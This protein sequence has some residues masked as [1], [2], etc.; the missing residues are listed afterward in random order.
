MVWGGLTKT[1]S[2]SKISGITVNFA[3]DSLR[4]FAVEGI[5]QMSDNE[6]AS[7]LPQLVQALKYDVY[8][9]SELGI[10]LIERAIVK[11]ALIGIP[12]FWCCKVEL[13]SAH[14]RARYVMYIHEYKRR[15]GK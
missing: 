12:F 10:F 4:N 2:N 9:T 3:L 6:I 13:R 5:R 15:C 1:K 8:D 14:C 7:C 11:P